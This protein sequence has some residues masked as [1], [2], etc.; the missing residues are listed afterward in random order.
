MRNTDLLPVFCFVVMVVVCNARG[1]GPKPPSMNTET[2][3]S[4]TTEYHFNDGH[5]D[6][7][8]AGIKFDQAGDMD[9]ALLAFEAA[10]RYKP[11]DAEAQMNL[12]VCKMRIGTDSPAD[13]FLQ[14]AEMHFRHAANLPGAPDMKKKVEANQEMLHKLR[15]K[16][17]STKQQFQHDFQHP[18]ADH[19]KAGDHFMNTND[20]DSALLAFDSAVWFHPKDPEAHLHLGIV[21]LRKGKAAGHNAKHKSAQGFLQT[22]SQHLKDALRHAMGRQ[23]T[24]VHRQIKAAKA[25]VDKFL[26][27]HDAIANKRRPDM[28]FNSNPRLPNTENH[29]APSGHEVSAWE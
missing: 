29:K 17:G 9:G 18:Q 21:K 24:G 13:G 4:V 20:V 23:H 5:A 15:M 2:P 7:K 8:A 16:R 27:V 22:A 12:G 26:A 10:A 28:N 19:K 11:M 25:D 6:H 14:H 3:P 1:W